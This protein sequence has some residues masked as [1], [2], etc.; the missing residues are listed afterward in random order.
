MN[1]WHHRLDLSLS[2]FWEMVKGREAWPAAVHSVAKSRT[3]LSDEQ[4][5][6]IKLWEFKEEGNVKAEVSAKRK[7]G[8][9][10]HCFLL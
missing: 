1:G 10:H 2:R 8:L 3:Q 4:Q 5:Q 9:G 6:H 7:C